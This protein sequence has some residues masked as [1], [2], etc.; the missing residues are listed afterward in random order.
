MAR[1]RIAVFLDRD[2]TINEEMGYLN[3][4]DRFFFRSDQYPYIRYGIPAVW[5]FCGT[6]PDYH[7]ERDVEELC[8][9]AKM[10]KVTRLVYLTAMDI[11]NKPALL[12]LDVHPEIKTRGAHN[13][14]VVWRRPPQPQVKK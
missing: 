4:P 8:D 3:H 6:T 12:K 7:T 11:G 5:F 1:K 10:E 9:Y 13:M 2:G 14:S